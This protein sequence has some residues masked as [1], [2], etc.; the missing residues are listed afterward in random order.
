MKAAGQAMIGT[1][2]GST[3]DARSGGASKDVGMWAIENF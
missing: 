3:W 2:Q 1:A